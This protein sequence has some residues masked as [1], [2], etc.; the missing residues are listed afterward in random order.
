[1]SQCV[2]AIQI[3]RPLGHGKHCIFLQSTLSVPL[4]MSE[5]NNGQALSP[6]DNRLLA[7]KGSQARYTGEVLLRTRPRTYRKV[8]ALLAD[9][10]WSVVR[11]AQACKVS[12]NTIAAV[13]LREASTI[14]ERKKT[15][16]SVLVDVATKAAEQMECKVPRGSLRDVTV[17]MGVSTDKV[18]AL[19]GQTPVGIQI[20][21]IQMPTPKQDEARRRAHHALDEITRLLRE[22]ETPENELLLKVHL[23]R[24][25][26]TSSQ[27]EPGELSPVTPSQD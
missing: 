10:D 20:A 4:N 2:S 26:L 7:P 15:L 22:P 25:E 16:T 11:I 24:L 13:R 19:Q 8:V 23:K 12:E 9:P 21:N 17:A 14:E 18:L 6:K 27:K 1:L 3:V 5:P